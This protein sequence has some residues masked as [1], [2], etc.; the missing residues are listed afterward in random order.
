MDA[1]LVRPPGLQLKSGVGVAGKTLQYPVMGHGRLTVLFGNRHFFAVHRMAA[2][3]PIYISRI[4]FQIAQQNTVIYPFHRVAFYLFGQTQVG[5]IGL[6]HQEQAAGILINAM[7]DAR[8]CD[9]IDAGQRVTTMV[10]QG[11]D[12][13]TAVMPGTIPFG[14]LI[15]SKWASSYR[16]S[17]SMGSGCRFSGW[18]GGKEMV[19]LCPALSR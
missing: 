18:T 1:D 11:M 17:N 2:D 15:T 6:G 13:R 19:R 3:G 5:G 7:D 12:Q 16:I 4:L 8:P 14:L 10:E 9:T